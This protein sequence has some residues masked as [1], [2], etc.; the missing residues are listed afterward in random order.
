MFN[1]QKGGDASK[2]LWGKLVKFGEKD[3]GGKRT[4]RK[5][6]VKEGHRA[7]LGGKRAQTEGD[8][9]IPAGGGGGTQGRECWAGKRE[10]GA[11]HRRRA[12]RETI[13]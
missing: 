3:R 4:R 11:H 12:E 13:D 8:R 7:K 9:E 10:T 2:R 5:R 1:S 6:K